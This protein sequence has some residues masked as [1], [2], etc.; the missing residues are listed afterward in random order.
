MKLTLCVVFLAVLCPC[1]SPPSAVGA[2][3][4]AATD[5]SRG[6]RERGPRRVASGTD[7]PPPA[8]SGIRTGY[9]GHYSCTT[10]A[11]MSRALCV[12][13]SDVEP[14]EGRRLIKSGADVNARS[15][16]SHTKGMT[17]LHVAVWYKWDL[18]AVQL[19]LDAE[20]DVNA[21]D[22]RQ[23]SALIYAMESTPA[24]QLPLVEL[25]IRAGANVNDPGAKGMTPLMHAAM[26]DGAEAV[27]ML[28]AAGADVSAKDK[29]GWTALL[30]ATRSK[31]GYVKPVE[32]LIAAGADVNAAHNYGGT[33]LSSAAYNG[34]VEVARLLIKWGADVH[35]KDQAG[36]TPLICASINGHRQLVEL[37][38]EAGAQVPAKDRL[39]RTALSYACDNGHSETA[40]LLIAAGAQ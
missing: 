20:A 11:G 10:F 39:G 37:L 5:P 9:A 29:A 36:W 28:L 34:H 18:E 14:E 4:A 7:E 30:H 21:E 15:T 38:I 6:G 35:A 33:P 25:L 40:D 22:A 32:R 26:H 16:A 3:S 1:V 31:R 19:L 13:V 17:I 12:A 24:I 27:T 8:F 2:R 23:N